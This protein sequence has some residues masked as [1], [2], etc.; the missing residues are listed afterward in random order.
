MC[1]ARLLSWP[2]NLHH[3]RG[4]TIQ[5]ESYS[6]IH[7]HS[8]GP[9]ARDVGHESQRSAK[10]GRSNVHSGIVLGTFQAS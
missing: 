6:H 3:V 5:K 7:V 9:Q 1:A 8:N 10:S 2:E 4:R